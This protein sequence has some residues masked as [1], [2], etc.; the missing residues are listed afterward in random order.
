MSN[1]KHLFL[2]V[3]LPFIQVNVEILVQ[4]VQQTIAFN[5]NLTS[6]RKKWYMREQQSRR[7]FRRNHPR[8]VYNAMTKKYH[9]PLLTV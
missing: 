4:P 6:C 2:N 3:I 1:K 7:C 5:A 9:S 8:A